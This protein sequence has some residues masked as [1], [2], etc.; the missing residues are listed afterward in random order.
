MFNKCWLKQ[1]NKGREKPLK[2]Q[3]KHLIFEFFIDIALTCK[4]SM[5]TLRSQFAIICDPPDSPAVGLPST[6]RQSSGIL[7]ILWKAFWPLIHVLVTISISFWG[8]SP[9]LLSFLWPLCEP[10]LWVSSWPTEVTH[11]VPWSLISACVAWTLPLFRLLNNLNV[12]T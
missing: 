2:L 4:P 3:L 5:W 6:G 7:S 12:L 10:L 1:C 8:L 9:S 11:S